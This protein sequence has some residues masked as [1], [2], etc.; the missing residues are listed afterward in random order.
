MSAATRSRPLT[1]LGPAAAKE[2]VTQGEQL[3][4]DQPGFGQQPAVAE[5]CP[6]RCGT[7]AEAPGPAAAA[8]PHRCRGS[9]SPRAGRRRGAIRPA[10]R[11]RRRHHGNGAAPANPAAARTRLPPAGGRKW[12]RARGWAPALGGCR[13]RARPG[14]APPPAPAPPRR[15]LPPAQERTP[16][17]GSPWQNLFGEQVRPT[18]ASRLPR[19]GARFVRSSEVQSVSG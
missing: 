9:G 12:R 6:P 1:D 19:R 3:H 17:S 15:L 10:R 5:G 14:P 2:A 4:P 8:A 13:C 18:R 11:A 16:V 7:P